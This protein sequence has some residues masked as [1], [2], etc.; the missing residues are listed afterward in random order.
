M[1][2]ASHQS[3]ARNATRC[4][5]SA[6]A[7]VTTPSSSTGSFRTALCS[8]NPV[9]AVRSAP[10]TVAS[11]RNWSP[12]TGRARRNASRIAAHLRIHARS[13]IA[14]PPRP[15]TT[16][17]SVPHSAATSTPA[18][19][20]PPT[21]TSPSTTR[22]V[23]ESASSSA[24]AIPA[25]NAASASSGVSA[26]STSIRPL[27]RRTRWRTTSSGSDAGSQSRDMSTT[28]TGTPS[29]RAS[30]ETGRPP[31]ARPAPVPPR[32]P[33][34]VRRRPAARRRDRPRTAPPAAVR[35]AAPAPRTAPP[36]ATHRGRPGG[37]A[38]RAGRPGGPGAP[39]R[40]G[41]PRR[42]DARSDR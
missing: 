2:D 42:P 25:R 10:P 27:P 3:G 21:L 31:P 39:P 1:C 23:P 34:H 41:A 22:S 11:S 36:P 6:H 40:H 20:V 15:V 4:A 19:V 29:R 30:T 28:R 32:C 12:S 26:S 16:D 18:A 38:T 13:S 8:R 9:I 14:R 24:T 33:R 35:P 17:A 7:A 37:P 5:T